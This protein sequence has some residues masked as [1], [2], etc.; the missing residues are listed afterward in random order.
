MNDGVKDRCQ[1]GQR[2]TIGGLLTWITSM[3][4]RGLQYISLRCASARRTE[5]GT[6]TA[7]YVVVTYGGRSMEHDGRGIKYGRKR[8]F[9][10]IRDRVGPR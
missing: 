9:T 7:E 1:V 4:H 3:C 10:M 8:W 6:R 2:Y 5:H